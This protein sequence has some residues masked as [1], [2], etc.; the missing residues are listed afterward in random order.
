MRLLI[1]AV[2]RSA[3]TKS[4]VAPSSLHIKWFWYL[5]F[6]RTKK[7]WTF[8]YFC[9]IF[10]QCSLSPSC[11]ILQPFAWVNYS[12]PLHLNLNSINIK[13]SS[14]IVMG[15]RHQLCLPACLFEFYCSALTHFSQIK[16]S[17]KAIY[18]FAHVQ[19]TEHTV[20]MK[21][22]QVTK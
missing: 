6:H 20:Q 11:S 4:K 19:Q 12:A 3:K 14:I 13:M 8:H 18:L 7:S 21:S 2:N 17:S 22:I 15:K 5:I 9:Q 10:F 1:C 16:L